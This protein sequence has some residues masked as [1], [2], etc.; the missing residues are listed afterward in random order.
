M[1]LYLAERKRRYQHKEVFAHLSFF[2]RDKTM[3]TK[4][5]CYTVGMIAKN[6]GFSWEESEDALRTESSI[7]LNVKLARI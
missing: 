5:Q 4:T 6:C 2:M 1:K 3:P 7:F